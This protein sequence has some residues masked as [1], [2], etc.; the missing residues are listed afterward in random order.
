MKNYL[1]I[2]SLLFLLLNCAS[3]GYNYKYSNQFSNKINP[4]EIYWIKPGDALYP[5]KD[6]T[7]LAFDSYLSLVSLNDENSLPPDFNFVV[8][9]PGNHTATV[10]MYSPNFR[11]KSSVRIQFVAKPNQTVILCREQTRVGWNPQ[12]KSI[13]GFIPEDKNFISPCNN[14]I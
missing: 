1:I 12:A 6:L 5:T 9:K 14:E 8:L 3:G 10:R 2:F 7:L 11:S 4:N 13:D